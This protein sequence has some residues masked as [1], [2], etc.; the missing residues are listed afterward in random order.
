MEN[1]VTKTVCGVILAVAAVVIILTLRDK[2][3]RRA[4]EIQFPDTETIYETGED[5]AVLLEG[6]TARDRKD[7]DVTYSLMIESV[8]PRSDGESAIVS[9]VASDSSNNIAKAY[10]TVKLRKKPEY[11]PGENPDG[12]DVLFPDDVK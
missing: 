2:R 1:N 12:S 9:Y 7:G 4:P 3:D 5:T 11:P 10:R 6:V 8:V